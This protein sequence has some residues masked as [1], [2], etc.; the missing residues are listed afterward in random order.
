MLASSFGTQGHS[1]TSVFSW[2][3]PSLASY[4]DIA[5]QCTTIEAEVRSEERLEVPQH[6]IKHYYVVVEGFYGVSA[7]ASA[8]Q[9]T[10]G[11]ILHIAMLH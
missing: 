7:D 6:Q 3:W 4:D 8:G 9:L 5:G 1:A 2:I 10:H 11:E